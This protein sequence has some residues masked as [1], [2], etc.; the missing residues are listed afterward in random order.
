M[1]DEEELV[2]ADGSLSDDTKDN[3]NQNTTN[4]FKSSHNSST[5]IANSTQQSIPHTKSKNLNNDSN[6]N[7]V[8][9]VSINGQPQ[10][11]SANTPIHL[12]QSINK[13]TELLSHNFSRGNEK[14]NKS[15]P[16]QHTD[17]NRSVKGSSNAYEK[18]SESMLLQP[19]LQQQQH[20]QH[21]P[22]YSDDAMHLPDIVVGSTLLAAN[23]ANIIGGQKSIPLSRSPPK[24]VVND[25]TLDSWS[26]NEEETGTLSDSF[27][28]SLEVDDE[29]AD[30]TDVSVVSCTL[31]R[32]DIIFTHFILSQFYF[33]N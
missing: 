25:N 22:K 1:D 31:N 6:N 16:Q 4:A 30:L 26:S 33:C 9:R 29:V 28:E 21:P 24:I 5:V 14:M 18:S 12:S 19:K 15:L 20:Q 8:I 13:N 32:N 23:H 3:A 11:F 17:N 27:D 7:D 2:T 10:R